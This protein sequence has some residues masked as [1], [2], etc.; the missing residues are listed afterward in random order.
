MLML[1][2]P[3]SEEAKPRQIRVK[4]SAGGNGEKGG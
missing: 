2:L 1:T 3:K 4:T